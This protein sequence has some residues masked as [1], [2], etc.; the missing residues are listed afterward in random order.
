VQFYPNSVHFSCVFILTGAFEQILSK[1]YPAF[2]TQSPP[3]GVF[4][5]AI[6]NLA[7]KHPKFYTHPPPTITK[8]PFR[9]SSHLELVFN[10]KGALLHILSTQEDPVQ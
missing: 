2:Q 1:Q 8:H 4:K 9:Y 7:D 5:Q 3:S 6:S 10:S